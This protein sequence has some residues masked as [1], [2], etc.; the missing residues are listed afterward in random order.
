[1]ADWWS[2]GL[3]ARLGDCVIALIAGLCEGGSP[4]VQSAVNPAIPESAINNRQSAI[5]KFNLQ[6]AIG[7]RQ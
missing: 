6:S 1:M 3:I 4:I 5:E 2:D 7:N